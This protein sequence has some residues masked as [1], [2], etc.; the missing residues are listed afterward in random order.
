LCLPYRIQQMRSDWQHQGT[1]L[2]FNVGLEDCD[3]LI[4]DITQALQQM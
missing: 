2:R 3:D 1:L 4:A